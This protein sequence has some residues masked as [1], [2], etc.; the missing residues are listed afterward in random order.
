MHAG[1]GDR[2]LAAIFAA[3]ST[4]T[5]KLALEEREVVANRNFSV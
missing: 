1:E 4:I 2:F 3:I 5:I